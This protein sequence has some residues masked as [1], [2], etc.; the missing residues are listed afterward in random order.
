M[1]GWVDFPENP[2]LF[3]K[4]TEEELIWG[5]E[6]MAR[7]GGRAL[8]EV[9]G[10]DIGVQ[11]TLYERFVCIYRRIPTEREDYVYMSFYFWGN[12]KTLMWD[13]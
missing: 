13:D 12:F 3:R 8:G 1:C 10:G 9:E 5:R 4:E 7:A 11:D 2:P 6:A